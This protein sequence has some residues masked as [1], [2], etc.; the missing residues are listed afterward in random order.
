MP[1]NQDLKELLRL[2]EDNN[3]MLHKMRRSAMWGG[4]IKFVFYIVVLVLAPLWLYSTY[5]APIV[6]Q[7]T[8]TY[9]EMQ[10]TGAQAQM[11]FADFQALLKQ[12]QERFST[13]N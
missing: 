3:R 8:A 5:L 13:G 7:M 1:P 12:L 10:G 9:K 11:Q 2:T 4:I 6:E